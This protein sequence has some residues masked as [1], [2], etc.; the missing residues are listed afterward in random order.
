MARESSRT[1]KQSCSL[2]W[3][4]SRSRPRRSRQWVW[5]RIQRGGLAAQ[6]RASSTEIGLPRPSCCGEGMGWHCLIRI[7]DFYVLNTKSFIC[8]KFMSFRPTE[9]AGGLWG[10]SEEFWTRH[11]FYDSFICSASTESKNANDETEEQSKECD[12][13]ASAP[14]ANY[15]NSLLGSKSCISRTLGA[16]YLI[17]GRWNAWGG[18][19]WPSGG[20]EV[21][22]CG[23]FP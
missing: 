4:R 16:C 14:R 10:E 3:L 9:F 19:E 2:S 1:R 15:H 11:D 5:P 18:S 17:R 20:L 7:V 13:Q 21:R 8:S 12:L 23:E 6:T 22:I